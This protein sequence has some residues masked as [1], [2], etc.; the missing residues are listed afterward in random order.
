VTHSLKADGGSPGSQG[1]Q[2]QTVGLVTV[3]ADQ[4]CLTMWPGEAVDGEPLLRLDQ[5]AL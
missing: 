5:Q 2:E 3:G 1:L 4:S